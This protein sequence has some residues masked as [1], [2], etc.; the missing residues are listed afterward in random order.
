MDTPLADDG[1]VIDDP[2]WAPPDAAVVVEC[3]VSAAAPTSPQFSTEVPEASIPDLNVQQDTTTAE[4]SGWDRR[5]S[6]QKKDRRAAFWTLVILGGMIST[7]VVWVTRDSGY[8]LPPRDPIINM[9]NSSVYLGNG[10]FWHTQYDM[11]T[12]EKVHFQRLHPAQT[13][14][15]V[16]YAGG[17]YTSED[18]LV[19]YHGGPR[20]A[21]YSENGHA[22]V[23]QVQLDSN[24]M[25][26]QFLQLLQNYFQDG[27]IATNHAGEPPAMQRRDYR[28]D[29]GPEYRNIIGLPGGMQSKLYH[30]IAQANIYQMEI[31]E[32]GSLGHGGR[33]DRT[34]NGVIYI[35]DSLVYRFYRAEQ[36]HQFHPNT[37]LHRDVAESY[38]SQTRKIQAQLGRIPETG[39]PENTASRLASG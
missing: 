39:C 17:L 4:V 29:S 26:F 7:F 15:L 19:C 34:D 23:A 11:Y 35:Y 21:S 12:V 32:G 6:N 24:E 36:Y 5:C 20:G 31:K 27:F 16:G 9:E 38:L 30:L 22:E 18:G 10:C 13:T 37:V 2:H 8:T 25:E 14:A 33:E 1:F 3:P 28:A